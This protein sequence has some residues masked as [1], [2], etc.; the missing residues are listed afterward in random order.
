VPFLCCVKE[1]LLIGAEGTRLLREL[2]ARVRPMQ[3]DPRR[4][5][6]CAPQE[7]KRR[8]GSPDAPRKASACSANQQSTFFNTAFLN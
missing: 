6:I 4:G 1:Q 8:G 3:N 2:A 5:I 7:Q